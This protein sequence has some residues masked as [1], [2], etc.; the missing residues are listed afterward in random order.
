MCVC[1]REIGCVCFC[2]CV[3]VNICVVCVCVCVSTCEHEYV[4]VCVCVCVC[5]FIKAFLM[6]IANIA[7]NA[8][9]RLTSVRINIGNHWQ[10]NQ[11]TLKGKVSLYH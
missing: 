4:C 10:N 9:V 11:G 6:D 5:V 7:L 3:R 1:K 8:L 2:A